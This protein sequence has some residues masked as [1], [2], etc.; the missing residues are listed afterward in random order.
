MILSQTT[1]MLNHKARR[2]MKTRTRTPIRISR[3]TRITRLR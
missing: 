1:E 3:R 2:G